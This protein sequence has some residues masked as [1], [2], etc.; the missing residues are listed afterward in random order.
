MLDRKSVN[1]MFLQPYHLKYLVKMAIKY[2]QS[3]LL[4]AC[5]SIIGVC[6]LL[7]FMEGRA[8]AAKFSPVCI[9]SRVVRLSTMIFV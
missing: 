5:V 7:A 4:H 8:R 3:V 1:S 2:V 6:S 9:W